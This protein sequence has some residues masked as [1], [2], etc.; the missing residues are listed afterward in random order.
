MAMCTCTKCGRRF[1]G[2]GPFD[3]HQKQRGSKVTCLPPDEVGLKEFPNDDAGNTVWGTAV[4]RGSN[5][6][7]RN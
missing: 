6:R 7:K 1:T 5:L 4:P 2:L 3:R